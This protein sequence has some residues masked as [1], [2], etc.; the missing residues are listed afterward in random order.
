M[1]MTRFAIPAAALALLVAASPAF[2]PPPN[3][4]PGWDDIPDSALEVGTADAMDSTSLKLVVSTGYNFDDQ[5]TL[6]TGLTV[7][8]E[9]RNDVPPGSFG[10]RQDWFD[11][12]AVPVSFQFQGSPV[13]H[14]LM[15]IIV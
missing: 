14:E 7:K 8:A 15:T 4:P 11:N 3:N 12:V 2:R 6:L 1:F 9:I 10:E 5:E 13:V